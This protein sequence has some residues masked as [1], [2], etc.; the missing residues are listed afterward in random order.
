[1]IISISISTRQR[2]V[3]ATWLHVGGGPKI[4][5]SIS[6]RSRRVAQKEGWDCLWRS[7]GV[8][9]RDLHRI[10]GLGGIDMVSRGGFYPNSDQGWEEGSVRMT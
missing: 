6:N 7:G 2:G 3:W 1:M 5:I 8:K 10:L 4:S 9:N